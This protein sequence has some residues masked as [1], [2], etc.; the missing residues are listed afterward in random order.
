MTIA[1]IVGR[2]LPAARDRDLRQARV[3]LVTEH[4]SALISR[5]YWHCVRPNPGVRVVIRV[6]PAE[7]A[8]KAVLSI[9]VTVAAVALGA[10]WGP[11]LAGALGVSTAIG[12]ALVIA[13]VSIVGNLLINALIPP[14]KP[15]NEKRNSYSI[16]GLRNR[17]DPDGAV[18]F[19]LGKMRYAPPYAATPYTE[20]VGDD[21]YIRALF[22]FGEG[23]L[24]ITDMRL[25]ETSLAEYDEVETEVRYG[26]AGELPCSLYPRQ[27]VEEQIGVELT[28]PLPRDD[29]GDVISGQPTEDVP[30]VR[31]TGA[32]ASGATVIF[33]WPAGLV[34]FNDKGSKRTRAVSIRIEHRL[35]EADQWQLV[36]TL[37]ITAKK[38]EGFYRQYSWDFPTRAR[39][40]VRV[41]MLTDESDSSNV[42][43]RTTWVALQTLRPEY[44]LD[45]PRPLAL[46]ALRIK[47]THQLNGQLDNFN[48]LVGRVCPDWDAASG[49]WVRRSTERPASLYREI[50]QHASNPKAVADAGIDLDL[51]AEWHEHSEANSLTYNRVLEG[52]D[53]TLRDILTE[54]AAAG[55]ATPRHDG[56]KWGV[57]IDRPSRDDLI[58][59]HLNP[60]NSWGFKWSRSYTDAPDAFVVKFH[61]AGN[62]YKETQRI[63]PWPGHVGAVEITEELSLPGKVYADEVWRE[64]RRRQL[65]TIYRPDTFEA[66]QDGSA[67]VVTRGDAIALSHYVLS[68]V[69]SAARVRNVSG[70]VIELDETVTMAAGTS[71][72]IRFRVFDGPSDTIGRSVVREAITVAGESPLLT[73]VGDSNLPQVG[74]LVHFG[75][76]AS[77][78][79]Q[80]IV[81]GIEITEDM[82]S[83][84]RTVDAAPEID[85]ELAAT[86]VPAWSSRVGA[87]LDENLLQPSAPRFVSIVSGVDG[88]DIADLIVYLIEP[89][90]GAVPTSEFDIEHKSN[91]TATWTSSRLPI[92]NGGGQITGYSNGNIVDI[93]ARGVSAT[94][95]PGPYTPT[96][97]I[98]VGGADASIPAALDSEAVNITPVLGGVTIEIATGDDPAIASL[99]LYRSQTEVL[100]RETDASGAPI[101]AAP[102]RSFSASMGD[103]TR[104]ILIG[105]GAMDGA[106]SW[107]LGAGWT[108]GSGS[109]THAPGSAGALSQP[110][111]TE[112]GKYYRVAVT[113]SG[114]TAGTI[115]PKLTGGSDRSG[116][117]ITTDGIHSDRIQAVTGNDT[118]ELVAS[119]DFDGSVEDV[120]VYLETAACLTQGDHHI[121]VEP[122]NSDGV[123]GPVSGPFTATVL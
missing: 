12:T 58:V 53:T 61:D 117:S 46:V 67:R 13:G 113:V 99:Q 73:F 8:L 94:G 55:R 86:V 107:T 71:Y 47:A 44:P 2:A 29:N 66:T 45:Y 78:S 14:V 116:V 91:G 31:T 42:Q 17:L 49:T 28:R 4:G 56:Q 11:A 62:D 105:D 9:V 68:R 34:Q 87:E 70:R 77:E 43:Q 81:T 96:I 114:R 119:A 85:E 89:G 103:T 20:I 79:Y 64:A 100:D 63:I 112:S 110:L 35:A 76:V 18:P 97:T 101:S 104:Q 51:L 15:D 65:E 80:Q 93:R 25:G 82:C 75:P 59:D 108:I 1:E 16:N 98:T 50:L 92:A 3:A 36:D 5:E 22:C 122:Q 121:W 6:V 33:A 123:P 88:T 38:A 52:T 10:V 106:G 41:T 83:I 26:I 23:E 115:T 60:R 7:G 69:Q 111:T 118:F 27:V 74:D 57:V 90:S 109:A 95:I 72:A 54:V 102:L 40:Q 120:V 32:D 19:V 39:W 24:Q 30:V 84:V 48:A 21:Q 37:N